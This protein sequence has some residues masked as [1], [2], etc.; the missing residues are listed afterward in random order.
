MIADANN[1]TLGMYIRSAIVSAMD[2]RGK[3]PDKPLMEEAEDK[4]IITDTLTEDEQEAARRKMMLSM[5]L[6]KALLDEAGS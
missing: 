1:W 5:G 6:P 2:K 4:R 3:Y